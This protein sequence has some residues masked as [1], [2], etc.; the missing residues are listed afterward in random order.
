MRQYLTVR[1]LF[2]Y[3]LVATSA[4]H[5]DNAFWPAAEMAKK[6]TLAPTQDGSSAWGMRVKLG[7]SGLGELHDSVLSRMSHLG[8]S[9]ET[10]EIESGSPKFGFGNSH[11]TSMR[12][13]A[14][15]LYGR[16]AESD[17]HIPTPLPYQ[18]DG[19]IPGMGTVQS[20]FGLGGDYEMSHEVNLELRWN[21]YHDALIGPDAMK[22]QEDVFL[23]NFR[24][25]F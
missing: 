7:Q 13:V 6:A 17:G 1:L 25:S 24:M 14:G 10:V 5:A 18:A 22:T 19:D 2:M 4:V 11:R 12:A 3:T 9:L 16:S 20:Y 21:R 15:I 8:Q 23:A